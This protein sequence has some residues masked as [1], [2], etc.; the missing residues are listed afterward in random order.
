M[1][2]TTGRK[3]IEASD[4]VGGVFTFQV[5]GTGGNDAN[6]G[7]TAPKKTITAMCQS[8]SR[9]WDLGELPVRVTHTAGTYGGIP[10]FS[11]VGRGP[12]PTDLS[13]IGDPSNSGNC[14]LKP[15]S[16]GGSA[17]HTQGPG[18]SLYV[19]GFKTDMS[20][21]PGVPAVEV[22]N[23]T[24]LGLGTF[25]YGWCDS[26][27]NQVC[28]KGSLHYN[29]PF[30][31]DKGSSV[32]IAFTQQ[33][34]GSYVGSSCNGVPSSIYGVVLGSPR[35]KDS[36][37]MV[38][39]ATHY[40]NGLVF[41]QAGNCAFTTFGP[42]YSGAGGYTVPVH[43]T[44][45]ISV[46]HYVSSSST[47]Y[48]TQVTSI[49]TTA[50]TVTLN[51]PLQVGTPDGTAVIFYAK[52]AQGSPTSGVLCRPFSITNGGVIVSGT[53]PNPAVPAPDYAWLPG[54]SPTGGY[55][56]SDPGSRYV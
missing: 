13:F 24:M 53:S 48:G 38:D 18:F 37:A 17:I 19:D 8:I 5:D 51:A 10:Y 41:V 49:S 12:V 40:L 35:W 29:K 30:G 2:T 22:E 42:G 54:S 46:G 34:P 4:L 14:I 7:V 16:G 39:R 3:K 23:D 15:A 6:D 27:D 9:D 52:A 1:V 25:T 11:V 55:T 43:S 36:F 56:D 45:G 44:S 28:F 26:Y 47:L 33:D 20:N 21:N 32:G 31:I 50:S